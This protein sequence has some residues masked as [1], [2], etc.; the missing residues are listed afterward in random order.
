MIIK[1]IFRPIYRIYILPYF[2][3][4]VFCML[5]WLIR[6]KNRKEIITDSLHYKDNDN[7]ETDSY[8]YGNEFLQLIDFLNKVSNKF[9]S[10]IFSTTL[11]Y[12]IFI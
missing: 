8:P 9:I 6:A 3:L 10:I 4:L 5:I 12:S 11:Y 7:I 1:Y 2:A